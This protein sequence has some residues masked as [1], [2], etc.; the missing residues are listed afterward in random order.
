M[1]SEWY[2][3]DT[4]HDY[5]SG[6]E[7]EAFDDAAADSFR[8][9]LYSPVGVD[10]DVCN[11]DLTVRKRVRVIVEANTQDTRLNAL[12]RKILAPIGTCK[13]GQYVY[14]HNRYW[15]IVGMVDN[16][17]VYE[18]GVMLNCNYKITWLNDDGMVVQRWSHVESA[19]QYNNGETTTQFFAVRSD[20]LLVLTPNDDECLLLNSGKRFIIDNRTLVYEKR[21]PEGITKDTSNPILTYRITRLDSVLFSYEDSGHYE[22]MVYQDEQHDGDGYYVI[23]GNGYWLCEEPPAQ[24]PIP[25]TKRCVIDFESPYLYNGIAP[26]T[27][28]ARF[29]DDKGI[30]YEAAPTWAITGIDSAKLDV[31]QDG[32]DISIASN[33]RSLVGK[34]FKLTLIADGYEGSEL[35]VKIKAFS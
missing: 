19:S 15:L 30:E 29:V 23:D 35:T 33:D 25:R 5:V 2:L 22:F 9:A 4:N 14:H 8:E 16:N 21:F 18:K 27:F 1:A 12:Q 10:V 28:T 11:C 26:S 17:G 6:L 3:M 20:Q 32:N 13:A 34:T 31:V 7:G 24:T